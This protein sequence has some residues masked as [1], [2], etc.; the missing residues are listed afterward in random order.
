[1]AFYNGLLHITGGALSWEKCKAYLLQFYWRNGKKFMH[2]TKEMFPALDIL[3]IF[4][5]EFFQILLANPDEAF[6]ML[7]AYVA[8]DGNT[9]GQVRIL[10]K[11][12]TEWANRLER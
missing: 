1:M 8:P 12:T 4:T 7:G 10:L 11:K 9:E 3:D 2:M 5:D 6:K